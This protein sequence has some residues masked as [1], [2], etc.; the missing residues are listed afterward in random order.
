M[1]R[2]AGCHAAPGSDP[3][4]GAGLASS[5]NVGMIGSIRPIIDRSIPGVSANASGGPEAWR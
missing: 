4:P 5:E 1:T 3:V 2:A